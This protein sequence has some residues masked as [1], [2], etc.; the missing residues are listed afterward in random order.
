MKRTLALLLSLLLTMTAALPVLA[1][2]RVSAQPSSPEQTG[3]STVTFVPGSGDNEAEAPASAPE[4]AESG[5]AAQSAPAAGQTAVMT[6]QSLHDAPL[7]K[8]DNAADTLHFESLRS[9]LLRYNDNIIS[10]D[11]QLKDLSNTSASVDDIIGMC[12]E[13]TSIKKGIDGALNNLDEESMDPDL[14]YTLRDTLQGLSFALQVLNIQF[15]STRQSIIDAADSLD[16]ARNTLNNAINQIVKG[17]ETLYMAILTMEDAVTTMERS[18]ETLDRAVAITEKRLELGMASAFELETMRHQRSQLSSQIASMEYQISCS[19]LSLEGMCGM[20]L[21]GTVQLAP[22]PEISDTVLDSVNYDTQLSIAMERNVDVANAKIDYNSKSDGINTHAY[23]AAKRTFAAKFKA[24]CLAVP[25][26]R[27][28]VAA[29]QETVDYQQRSFDIAAKKYELG[30][31][32]HEEYLS[33]QE[34]LT[35]A[36]DELRAAERNLF[37]AYRDYENAVQYGLV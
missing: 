6:A 30:M 34:T 14:Y 26:Q 4:T 18:L 16:E 9:T 17:A 23:T 22:L 13:I 27:R 36:Q 5:T 11:G 3:Q 24:L 21:K 31:L 8:S 12:E 20:E 25:E 35:S 37:S 2:D 15:E 1:D 10:L 29:A 19:K 32:S 28:L 7:F 33:A